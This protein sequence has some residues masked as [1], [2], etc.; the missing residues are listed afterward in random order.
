MQRGSIV[1]RGDMWTLFYYDIDSKGKRVKTSVKLAKK[2]KDYPRESSVRV[3]AEK[4]LAPLNR[5]QVLPEA[6]LPIGQFI[7]ECYFPRVQS[8]LRPSTLTN[9]K[10]SIYYPHLKERLSNPAIKLRD[11][12]TVHGQRLLRTI[13]EV[14]HTTLLHIK[15]FLSGVFTFAL[16][17]GVLD[18]VNPMLH[19]T[20][21]GRPKKFEGAAY[22]LAET[23]R[24]IEDVE[25]AQRYALRRAK[26]SAKSP[27]RK[28]L[29]E[30]YET[31]SDVIAMLSLQVCGRAK[32]GGC[33]G[34][35]GMR[36]TRNSASSV[37]CGKR[38]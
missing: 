26:W 14:G 34:R 23:S 2:G 17:E 13:P 21:P 19:V 5:K 6:S 27:H 35:T 24:M 16:R 31:A 22:T 37:P 28:R 1:L 38:G 3:L 7:E 32:L 4:K 10:Q 18:G 20:V 12:Q 33:V 11:F 29:R 9:Y 15:N 30:T 36:Q 8:E 25:E